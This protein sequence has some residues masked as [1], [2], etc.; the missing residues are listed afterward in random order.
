MQVGSIAECS[1]RAFCKYFQH[2]LIYQLSLKPLFCLVLSGCLRQVLLYLSPKKCILLVIDGRLI[3]TLPKSN[4]SNELLKDNK[5]KC[6]HFSVQKKIASHLVLC[7]H[8]SF[9]SFN[10]C[11]KANCSWENRAC[12]IIN[13][14]ESLEDTVTIYSCN[15]SHS[16]NQEISAQWETQDM[17]IQLFLINSKSIDY[18]TRFFHFSAITCLC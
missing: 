4:T 2:S 6:W 16:G 17:L 14:G 3:E 11:Q 9:A 18:W 7:N 8:G 10:T 12:L 15:W 5:G 13:L 1:K